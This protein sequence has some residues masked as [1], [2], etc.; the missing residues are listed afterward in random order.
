MPGA[1][2]AWE[3]EAGG[4]FELRFFFL[5]IVLFL[6]LFILFHDMGVSSVCIFAHCVC[7]PGILRSQKRASDLL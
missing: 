6:D 5:N 3:A 4:S 1:L 7:V 2:A